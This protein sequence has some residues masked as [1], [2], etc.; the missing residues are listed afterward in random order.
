M[1]ALVLCLGFTRCGGLFILVLI[2]AYLL[3]LIARFMCVDFCLL[4]YCVLCWLLFV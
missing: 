4:F 1:F 2:F 3:R